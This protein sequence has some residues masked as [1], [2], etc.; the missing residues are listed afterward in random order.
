[1]KKVYKFYWDCYRSGDVRGVFIADDEDV[2]KAIGSK[3]YFGE[4][5]GKHSEIYGIL[6]EKDLTILTDDQEFIK[7]AEEFNMCSGYNPLHYLPEE[8]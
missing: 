7:K 6:E 3:V 1:M 5:L 2:K 4:I 8:E